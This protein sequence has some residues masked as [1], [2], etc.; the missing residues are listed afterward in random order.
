[1]SIHEYLS[2]THQQQTT[3]WSDVTG[4][5]YVVLRSG[6]YP[7]SLPH[8]LPKLGSAETSVGILYRLPDDVLT[9]LVARLYG[10][11][12]EDVGVWQAR[13]DLRRR[14]RIDVSFCRRCTWDELTLDE[15]SAAIL[16]GYCDRRNMELWWNATQLL[17]GPAAVDRA[18]AYSPTECMAV[19]TLGFSPSNWYGREP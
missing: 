7:P 5:G 11:Q 14:A 9:I 18:L 13:R 2:T 17:C 4:G 16:L 19:W 6:N 10:R 12:M 8:P 15:Q 1:M 3:S